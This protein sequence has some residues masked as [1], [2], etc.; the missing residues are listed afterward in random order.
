MNC[1]IFLP[2]PSVN[3]SV[4]FTDLKYSGT[5]LQT[6]AT[7]PSETTF[8]AICQK[9]TLILAIKVISMVMPNWYPRY[10][11]LFYDR[12]KETCVYRPW[13]NITTLPV[14]LVFVEQSDIFREG[15][16]EEHDAS[17]FRLIF[18]ADIIVL[19]SKPSNLIWIHTSKSLLPQAIFIAR[20]KY[21]DSKLNCF[22]IMTVNGEHI[23]EFMRKPL[24]VW[25]CETVLKRSVQFW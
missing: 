22:I 4:F 1:P 12:R 9:Y 18:S 13:S 3:L 23:V 7:G 19:F 14:K 16:V 17:T 20:V 21:P 10:S 25:L 11:R 6:T 2:H 15:D 24:L 5:M 8:P